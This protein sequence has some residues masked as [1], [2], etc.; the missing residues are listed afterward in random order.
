MMVQFC[1]L[2]LYLGTKTVSCRL[3]IRMARMHMEW[4]LK[5]LDYFFSSF[6]ATPANIAKKLLWLVLPDEISLVS[7]LRLYLSSLCLGEDIHD[8]KDH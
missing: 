1:Y 8:F 3:L 6:N 2:R 7:S 5:K 4:N